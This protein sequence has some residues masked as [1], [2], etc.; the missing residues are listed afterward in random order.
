MNKNSILLEIEN[1]NHSFVLDK[2]KFT[3]L[4]DIN[5]RLY[6]GEIFGIL[7]ESGSGKSTLARCIM[8]IYKYNG[9]IIYK[10]IEISNKQ[11]YK[12]HKDFINRDIQFVFQ[13]SVASLNPFMSI[14]NIMKEGINLH[15]KHLHID[16]EKQYILDLLDMLMLDPIILNLRP[17]EISGGQAQRLAIARALSLQPSLLIADEAIASL[18]A[19]IQANILN[20]FRRLN[21]NGLSI[22]FI[23]HNLPAVYNLCHRVAIMNE[24]KIVELANNYDIFNNPQQAYTKELLSYYPKPGGIGL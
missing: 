21:K 5:L 9:K 10:D 15:K 14:E 3:A 20:L 13:D 24:A 16:N 18:D 19:S 23:S 2:I 4:K 6:Q 7:G 11:Q 22:L 1:L 12:K 8:Q 17:C